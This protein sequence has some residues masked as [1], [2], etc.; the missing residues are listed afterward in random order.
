M[1]AAQMH[2]RDGKSDP[3]AGLHGMQAV[4]LL[5]Q[6]WK[7]PTGHISN[8][9]TMTVVL[10]VGYE[11]WWGDQDAAV[12]HSKGLAQ[13]VE[14][15]GGL[16]SFKDHKYMKVAVSWVDIVS[17]GI[18]ITKTRFPA[19]QNASRNPVT[20]VP[21]LFNTSESMISSV[22]SAYPDSH[23]PRFMSTNFKD[24][25]DSSETRDLTIHVSRSL[26]WLCQAIKGISAS[27]RSERSGAN[28]EIAARKISGSLIQ[29]QV[30]PHGLAAAKSY[31]NVLDTCRLAAITYI[32]TLW[33]II[34]P[35]PFLPEESLARLESSMLSSE[36]SWTHGNG[37][38]FWLVVTGEGSVVR[39]DKSADGYE[40]LEFWIRVEE[41]L[42]V[43]LPFGDDM[44]V[45][46][47]VD[48]ASKSIVR[49]VI[50]RKTEYQKQE[51]KW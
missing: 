39:Q 35:S 2:G 40:V 16:Q 21:A 5:N 17:A 12:M 34:H 23:S 15:K 33:Q 49:D 30:P 25:S 10:L 42:R 1:Y 48:W 11:Y 36:R 13:M 27:N 9:M 31:A 20:I 4:K 22:G 24:S 44:D 28:V 47:D 46:C 3:E 29:M 50:S 32:S 18:L 38:L 51:N 26:E 14:K 8:G 6:R 37:M 43:S 41:S 45:S 7:D 19:S